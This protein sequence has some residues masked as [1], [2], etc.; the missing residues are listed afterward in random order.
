MMLAVQKCPF[1][2]VVKNSAPTERNPP[3]ER[4]V[5]A[6]LL[7]PSGVAASIRAGVQ[8]ASAAAWAAGL[9]AAETTPGSAA[10]V[11]APAV[12]VSAVAIPK[13]ERAATAAILTTFI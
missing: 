10:L 8:Y 4:A 6:G 13:I 12:P 2:P 3:N 5:T 7:D 9:T 11:A 1:L